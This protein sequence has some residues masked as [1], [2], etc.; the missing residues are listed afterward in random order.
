MT[1]IIVT[2][3]LR[4]YNMFDIAN[5]SILEL[6]FNTESEVIENCIARLKRTSDFSG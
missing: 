6:T 1:F 5:G 4:I 2:E 3:V